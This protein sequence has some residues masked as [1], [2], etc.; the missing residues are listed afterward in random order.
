MDMSADLLLQHERASDVDDKRASVI[1]RSLRNIRSHH[2]FLLAR[3]TVNQRLV[4]AVRA[5]CMIS[6]IRGS[7]LQ[8]AL[9]G[10]IAVAHFEAGESMHLGDAVAFFCVNASERE[11]SIIFQM[12]RPFFVEYDEPVDEKVCERSSFSRSFL[13]LLD[14]PDTRPDV[15]G[16]S[17]Q[18]E[19]I[20]APLAP[21][22]SSPRTDPEL[23]EG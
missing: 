4:A 19:R 3:S 20:S 6:T 14:I 22:K 21:R 11:R 13:C 12:L 7:K 17:Q 2:V 10:M 23:E 5:S 16:V 8:R 9:R 18:V 15:S 1:E